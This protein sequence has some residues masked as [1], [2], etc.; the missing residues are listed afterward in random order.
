MVQAGGCGL[1]YIDVQRQLLQAYALEGDR[2]RRVSDVVHRGFVLELEF[3]FAGIAQAQPR[4]LAQ[5]AE[6]AQVV[7]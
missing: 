3:H 6:Q 1:R 4:A 5:V 2:K 7:A